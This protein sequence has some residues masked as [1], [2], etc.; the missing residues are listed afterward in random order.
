MSI[1]KETYEYVK[2]TYEFVKRLLHEKR[3][4]DSLVYTRISE[5]FFPTVAVSPFS[6]SN[7]VSDEGMQGEGER[8]GGGGITF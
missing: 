3:Q 4:T 7:A 8:G 1:S 6:P 2:E 5:P